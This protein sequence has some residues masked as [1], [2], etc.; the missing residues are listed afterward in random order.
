[1]ASPQ[2]I[3][4]ELAQ[5][6][7]VALTSTAGIAALVAVMALPVPIDATQGRLPAPMLPPAAP[8]LVPA[9]VPVGD[10]VISGGSR[11][12]L[13]VMSSLESLQPARRC[14]GYVWEA[15]DG[16]PARA[17]CHAVGLIPD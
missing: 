16:L 5:W 9:I 3:R 7:R 10:E 17:R 2:R 13:A 8:A 12:L 15:D 4:A 11:P 6:G 14:G 1:M